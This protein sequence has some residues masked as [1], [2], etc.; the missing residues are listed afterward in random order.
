L[1]QRSQK[2]HLL[3]DLAQGV[4]EALDLLAVG[5]HQ[6][7]RDALGAL[8][9]DSREPAQ[10]VDQRLDRPFVHAARASEGQ[11]GDLGHRG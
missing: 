3:G 5:I 8:R 4:R 9:S 6:V 2:P 1:K 7:E 11:A 10:L